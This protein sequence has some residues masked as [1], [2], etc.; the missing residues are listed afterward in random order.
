MLTLAKHRRNG[1]SVPS[2]VMGPRIGI[3]T[4]PQ[5]HGDR[6]LVALDRAYVEAVVSA[7]GTPLLL[8]VL[9]P[10]HVAGFAAVLDGLVVTGGP[11]VDPARYNRSPV[12][13]VYGVDPARDEWEIALVHHARM[14][15]IP[16][17]G[18]CRGA[19]LL[20][21][22]HGGS[23]VLD[24]P[25]IG[26]EGHRRLDRMDQVVHEV[27]IVSGTTLESVVGVSDDGILGVN[28]LHHQSVDQVGH[29]LIVSACAPDGTI[30]AVETADGSPVLGV[31]WHPELLAGSP[32]HGALF[33]WL[34]HHA[35]RPRLVPVEFDETLVDAVA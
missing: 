28:S 18:I 7:G 3:T 25:S 11:D 32:R 16:V 15:R 1:R 27:S 30:E 24:L 14:A 9:E 12:P 35:S 17:L 33:E 2:W 34:T 22:A 29:G 5:E 26:R 6:H 19:Q 20:N 23:L 21:I 31:Q 8:P 10:Q 13:E 4:S